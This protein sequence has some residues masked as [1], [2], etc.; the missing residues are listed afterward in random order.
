[1]MNIL[2]F[3]YALTMIVVQWSL[4]DCGRNSESV[5]IYIWFLKESR[6]NRNQST[7]KMTVLYSLEENWN[8][9]VSG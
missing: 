4:H 8:V 5:M 2:S 1:M 3:M 7:V 9:T 6:L